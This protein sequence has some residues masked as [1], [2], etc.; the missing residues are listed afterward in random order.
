[1]SPSACASALRVDGCRDGAFHELVNGI[2]EE[3]FS[4]RHTRKAE[5]VEASGSSGSGPWCLL[6]VAERTPDD[7]A[8]EPPPATADVESDDDEGGEMESE[9]QAEPWS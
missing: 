9:P 6:G 7:E 4:L 2:A 3:R 8:P 1:M 5:N